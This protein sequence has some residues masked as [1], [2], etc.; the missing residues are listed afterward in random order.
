MDAGFR[1]ERLSGAAAEDHARRAVVTCFQHPAWVRAVA[2]ARGRPHELRLVRAVWADGRQATLCGSVHR[3]WGVPVFESMPMGGYGGWVTVGAVEWTL[4]PE[5]ERELFSRWLRWDR[6]PV[7]VL[8]GTPGRQAALP[9]PGDGG[10]WP[11]RLRERLAPRAFETHV[12]GLQADDAGLL[13]TMRPKL[14]GVLRRVDQLGF[15]WEVQH[16]E[17]A[18]KLFYDWY[19]RG[20]AQ[21]QQPA[22]ALLPCSFFTAFSEMPGADVWIVRHEGQM[23]GAALFLK[24]REE[25]QYQAAGSLRLNSPLSVSEVVLWAAMRHYRDQGLKSLNFGASEGLGS[26]AWFK[27]KFGAE[28]SAYLR[29]TYVFPSWRQGRGE[30]AVCTSGKPA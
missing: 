20:S 26:V 21:W 13:S 6:W 23:A 8:T 29:V 22:S 9:A 27:A 16:G 24:G 19:R 4:E 2:A 25:V 14:R 30:A 11:R 10:L 15:E 7:V 3:R 17:A 1:F 18:L 28:V 5:L 12:L